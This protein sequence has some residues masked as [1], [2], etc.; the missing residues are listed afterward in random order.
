[1]IV[2]IVMIEELNKL[3]NKKFLSVCWVFISMISKTPRFFFFRFFIEHIT[4]IKLS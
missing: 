2:I 1:M 4:L 3:Q